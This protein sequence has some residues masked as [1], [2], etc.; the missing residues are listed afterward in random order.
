MCGS[1]G[2]GRGASGG[3]VSLSLAGSMEQRS[4]PEFWSQTE[5]GPNPASFS[6]SVLDLGHIISLSLGFLSSKWRQ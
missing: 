2:Q 3:S 4:E 6:G 1:R 5:L